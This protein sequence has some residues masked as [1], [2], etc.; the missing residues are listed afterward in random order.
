MFEHLPNGVETISLISGILD[1]PLLMRIEPSK[2]GIKGCPLMLEGLLEKV[3]AVL[4]TR[5]GRM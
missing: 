2:L 5:V 4:G 3:Q 1:N